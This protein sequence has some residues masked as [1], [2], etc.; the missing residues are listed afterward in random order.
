MPGAVDED[1][2]DYQVEWSDPLPLWYHL[3]IGVL[4]EGD[5]AHLGLDV[6]LSFQIRL[7]LSGRKV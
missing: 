6:S 5:R 2:R 4:P 3:R 1:E 7:Q